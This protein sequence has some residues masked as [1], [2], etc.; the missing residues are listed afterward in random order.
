MISL[1]SFIKLKR[2][3]LIIFIKRIKILIIIYTANVINLRV[4][5]VFPPFIIL[6]IF[7]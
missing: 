1:I 3:Y 5:F 4:S 2:D 7:K 6:I